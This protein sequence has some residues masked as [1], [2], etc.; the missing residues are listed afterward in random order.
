MSALANAS[1]QR[2]ICA[3][4]FAPLLALGALPAVAAGPEGG[5]AAPPHFTLI[6]PALQDAHGVVGPA[7][8]SEALRAREQVLR[9]EGRQPLAHGVV[10]P[11]VLERR[12]PT[13]PC[14]AL[15]LREVHPSDRLGAGP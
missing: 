1:Q 15:G 8:G 3:P 5:R 4:T 14:R 11:C 12:H 13:R 10:A 9:V 2:P 7:P 6:H